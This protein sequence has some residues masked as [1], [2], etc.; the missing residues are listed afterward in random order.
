MLFKT[1]RLQIIPLDKTAL[2]TLLPI[3]QD[4]ETMRFIPNTDRDWTLEELQLRYAKNSKNDTE[5]LGVYQVVCKTTQKCI[6]EVGLYRNIENNSCPEIGYLLHR[7]YWGQGLGTE[8]LLGIISYAQKQPSFNGLLARM[9]AE[10]HA[11]LA[12]CLKVGF[13][14]TH[15]DILDDG[16]NRLTLL[17]KW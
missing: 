8:L 15:S 7:N 4:K 9:Y 17:L 13:T 5:Q 2:E 12:L 10:H 16:Q 3:Y 14:I 1:A 6:G 11:S